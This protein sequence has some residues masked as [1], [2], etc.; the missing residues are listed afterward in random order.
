MVAGRPRAKRAPYVDRKDHVE[1]SKTAFLR[2]AAALTEWPMQRDA[3]ALA[4]MEGA[5]GMLF[6]AKADHDD[7][8]LDRVSAALQHLLVL[9]Q[10][11]E[12]P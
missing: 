5:K 12:K 8:A 6:L 1:R 10:G 4:L 11:E 3:L 2:A 7:E 9:K